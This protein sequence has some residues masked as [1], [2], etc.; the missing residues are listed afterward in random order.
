MTVIIPNYFV[1]SM[2]VHAVASPTPSPASAAEVKKHLKDK[3]WIAEELPKLNGIICNAN[4]DLPQILAIYNVFL[5]GKFQ[6][7]HLPV[8]LRE[9]FLFAGLRSER[10]A[11]VRA[12]LQSGINP[13]VRDHLGRTPLHVVVEM[14][15]V[16]FEHVL[17]QFRADPEAQLYDEKSELNLATAL[18]L[19]VESSSLGMVQRLLTREASTAAQDAKGR[20]PLMLSLLGSEAIFEVLLTEK[21]NLLIPNAEGNTCLH[22]AMH[23]QVS[24]KFVSKLLAKAKQQGVLNTLLEVVN[25]QDETPLAVAAQNQKTH[26]KIKLLRDQGASISTLDGEFRTPLHRSVRSKSFESVQYLIGQQAE[27]DVG[28]R[29]LSTPVHHSIYAM[30]PTILDELISAEAD[31]NAVDIYGSTPLAIA[32]QL[33]ATLEELIEEE[34]EA[35]DVR[36]L[37]TQ[38]CILTKMSETLISHKAIETSKAVPD[39]G[40]FEDAL[41]HFRNEEI[42]WFDQVPSPIDPKLIA[43]DDRQT[44]FQWIR[45]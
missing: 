36:L 41:T 23:P 2:D 43:P 17:F 34:G 31:V 26:A 11:V 29:T 45:V 44:L 38:R 30:S 27:V 5:E 19:A 1:P 40:K 7:A 10:E 24:L 21:Q 14:E 32:R 28:D 9:T 35:L 15:L 39:D 42:P 33:I 16:G 25:K 13:N 3:R 20:T 37:Q 18:H 12:M 4:L 22:L 8:N 6:M